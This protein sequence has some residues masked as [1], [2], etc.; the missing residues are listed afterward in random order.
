[1][2][3]VIV[4]GAG[5]HARAVLDVLK[6]EGRY[7][8]GGLIDSFQKPGTICFGHKILGGEKE[9][10]DICSDVRTRNVF[11]AIGDNYQRQAMAERVQKAVSG[12][13]F[14]TCIH[15]SAII[16]SDVTIGKGTVIM[17]GVIIVSGCT[18]S[19]GC[20]L[21]TTSSIDHDGI[22]DNWSSLAPGVIAGGRIRLG[23]RSAVGLGAKVINDISIGR[24]TLVGAGAMV[25]KDISDNVLA[26]GIPCRVIRRRQSGEPYL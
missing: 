12:I 9:L 25:T 16:G 19:E 26:Y 8:I 2:T 18:I 13:K 22:M 17:P 6:S 24:D 14:I 3:V 7:R 4:I 1:M 15:H 21:N 20:L 5:G 10:P 11:I 23:K